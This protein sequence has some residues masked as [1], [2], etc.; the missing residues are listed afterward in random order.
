VYPN[1]FSNKT[2]I[3]FSITQF[4][5]TVSPSGLKIYDVTGRLVKNFVLPTSNFSLPTSLIWDGTDDAGRPVT[6]GVY[7]LNFI[8]GDYKKIEKAILLR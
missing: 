1:P 3:K 4:S 2:K 7:F 8:V 6:A 5:T